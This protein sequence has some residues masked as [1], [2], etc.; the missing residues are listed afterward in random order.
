MLQDRALIKTSS[1]AGERFAPDAKISR[2]ADDFLEF[3]CGFSSPARAD[4]CFVL[5]LHSLRKADPKKFQSLS[6]PRLRRFPH[7]GFFSALQ[8]YALSEDFG[9]LR[10]ITERMKVYARNNPFFDPHHP[11]TAPYHPD[12]DHLPILTGNIKMQP[13]AEGGRAV[14]LWNGGANLNIRPSELKNPREIQAEL[15]ALLCEPGANGKNLQSLTEVRF[16]QSHAMFP[17]LAGGRGLFARQKIPAGTVIGVVSGDCAYIGDRSPPV[18]CSWPYAI[19]QNALTFRIARSRPY[20]YLHRI[21]SYVVGNRLKF[22]NTAIPK[23]TGASAF[24]SLKNL[25]D[26]GNTGCFFAHFQTAVFPY[27]FSLPFYMSLRNID[28]GEEL[29]TFYPLDRGGRSEANEYC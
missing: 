11:K 4:L 7:W 28:A 21:D 24:P 12:C 18:L 10:E 20:H 3:T 6:V 22:V 19:Y 8:D 16:H 1:Q 25:P 17:A 5:A 14:T 2:S 13:V 27:Y 15:T 9:S 26:H 29:F 23:I